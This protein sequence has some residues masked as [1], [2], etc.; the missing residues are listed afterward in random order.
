MLRGRVQPVERANPIV[1]P[2]ALAERETEGLA[3]R[4]HVGFRLAL[5]PAAFAL[6]G[7]GDSG[8][9]VTDGGGRGRQEGCSL[10]TEFRSTRSIPSC[11]IKSIT[12]AC[13][14]CRRDGPATASACCEDR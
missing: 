4:G 5:Q 6:L 8:I 14:K 12:C 3:E 13:G 9:E 1:D 7:V 11:G 2:D 10:Q